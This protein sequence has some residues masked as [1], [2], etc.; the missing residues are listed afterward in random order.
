V[1]TVK[2]CLGGT[3]DPVHA[4]HI[5]T[6]KALADYLAVPVNL[7]PNLQP[8]HRQQP[9]ATAAQ[10]L[11]MLHMACEDELQLL[12]D[13]HEL[14]REGP[15]YTLLTMQSMRQELGADGVLIW[16]MGVD[17]FAHLHTWYG[18][19]E[20]LDYGHILVLDRPDS[21]APYDA[22]LLKFWQNHKVE[23]PKQLL[24]SPSGHISSLRLPQ[25]A[26]SATAIRAYV[27]QGM[28]PPEA[29]LPVNIAQYVIAQNLYK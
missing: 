8:A 16:C 20:L 4:G 24:Q 5:G 2:V 10:R 9:G 15:S 28:C 25:Y 6:A 14:Q 1:T 17:A 12:V 23:E 3:F 19:R 21:E 13:D 11:A 22:E 27:Q 18:W 7:L 29:M 26:I